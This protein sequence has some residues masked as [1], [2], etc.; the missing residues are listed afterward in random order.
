MW[1]R[2][3]PAPQLPLC[4]PGKPARSEAGAQPG[5]G[6]AWGSGEPDPEEGESQGGGRGRGAR[7]PQLPPRVAG[8]RGFARTG[9]RRIMTVSLVLSLSMPALY[10]VHWRNAV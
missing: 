7:G 8:Q 5:W 3:R 10:T 4:L 2:G 9:V 1:S 6:G